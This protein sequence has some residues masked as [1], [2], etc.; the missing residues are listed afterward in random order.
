MLELDDIRGVRRS[1]WEG[2][3]AIVV[4]GACSDG[5]ELVVLC[6]WPITDV[7][8]CDHAAEAIRQALRRSEPMVF[9]ELISDGAREPGELFRE[10]LDTI[11]TREES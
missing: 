2:I 8:R 9:G 6:L 7:T 10:L 1:F 4:P 5:D 3:Q 11:Y